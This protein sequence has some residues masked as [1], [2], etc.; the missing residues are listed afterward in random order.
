MTLKVEFKKFVQRTV[1]QRYHP[2]LRS[3]VMPIMRGAKNRLTL[4]TLVFSRNDVR[5]Q[6]MEL[7]SMQ[8][9]TDKMM[10]GLIKTGYNSKSIDAEI[11]SRLDTILSKI[12]EIETHA[13][14][15]DKI[16]IGLRKMR[17]NEHSNGAS[18]PSMLD[19]DDL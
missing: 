14:E 15:T 8:K 18:F 6:I 10:I 19:D 11:F 9:E 7:L 3:K 16:L 17:Y 4:L 13:R 2:F 5:D 12:E 1:P